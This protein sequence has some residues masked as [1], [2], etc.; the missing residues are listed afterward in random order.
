MNEHTRIYVALDTYGKEEVLE[1]IAKEL[2]VYIVVEEQKYEILRAMGRDLELY[3]TNYDE[4][5]IQVITKRRMGEYLQKDPLSI[6]LV[7]S[8]WVNHPTYRN[9]KRIYVPLSSLSASPTVS[10]PTSRKS[11]ISST[12]SGQ[13]T[14][15][16]SSSIILRKI[17][18]SIQTRS[19][20]S[21]CSSSRN[22][23]FSK[24]TRSI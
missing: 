13:A 20:A 18:F 15:N 2:E 3:T 6:C 19:S 7:L 17:G 16:P 10:T 9:N 23:L 1:H 24:R 11:T 8:G 22:N 5:F 14:S 21:A 4:G 12:A